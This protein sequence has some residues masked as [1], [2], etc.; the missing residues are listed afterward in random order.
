MVSKTWNTKLPE[1][2][3][4]TYI[5]VDHIALSADEETVRKFFAFC[6]NVDSLELQ[7]QESGYQRA[8]IKF[9]TAEAANTALLLSHALIHHEAIDV[10]PLFPEVSPATPPSGPGAAQG[11]QQPP[12]VSR[13]GT[14]ADVNYEG[15]PALYVAHE[16]LAAGYMLGESVLARASQFDAKYRVSDRTQTQARSM[17]NQ[18]KFSNYLQQWDDKFKISNRAKDAYNKLQSN[19]VGQKVILTVNDAYQSALQLS[20]DA[21]D[22]AERKRTN[23]ER[24]FGKIPLP[25]APTSTSPGSSSTGKP[26]QPQSGSDYSS[27]PVPPTGAPE[28]YQNEKQ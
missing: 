26:A 25:R 14:A 18:Y 11:Q 13:S 7:K 20:K 19:S 24:L 2:P 17:D 4:P 1:T 21:R 12:Q 23:D 10:T 28:Q 22:I 3:D 9:D 16:L 15:K 6:G 8:L 5:V 27:S